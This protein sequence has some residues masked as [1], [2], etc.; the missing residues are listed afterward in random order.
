M[1]WDDFRHAG[2]RYFKGDDGADALSAALGEL[3]DLYRA[4]V[5]RPPQVAEL[6]ATLEATLRAHGAELLAD[7][8]DL[9]RTRITCVRTDDVMPAPLVAFH[10]HEVFYQTGGDHVGYGVARRTPEQD[11]L[12]VRRLEVVGR[13]L[14]LDYA[15]VDDAVD[16]EVA[17]MLLRRVLLHDHLRDAY[18]GQVDTIAYRNLA[19]G[20]AQHARYADGWGS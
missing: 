8:A 4:R 6:L 11:V 19:S 5:G 14:H 13:V 10:A 12:L 17:V 18:R 15:V 16:D 7:P 9:D 3:R 1:A 20:L 2:R